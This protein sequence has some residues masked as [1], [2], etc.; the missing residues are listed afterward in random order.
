MNFSDFA[1]R[2]RATAAAFAAAAA[3]VAPAVA[4]VAAPAHPL[5]KTTL[6]RYEGDP[7]ALLSANP[8]GGLPLIARVRAFAMSD[9]SA[10]A[11][12]IALARNANDAQRAAIGAGLAS[13]VKALALSDPKAA[14][15]IKQ[16]VAQSGID[17]LITAFVA[18]SAPTPA[19]VTGDAG[20]DGD[21]TSGGPPANYPPG[22]APP[23]TGLPPASI[24]TNANPQTGAGGM[25]TST[26]FSVSPSR[27]SL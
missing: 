4:Q 8:A 5:S 13:A 1:A 9:P 19:V 6:E 25:T 27:T 24:F 15:A 12:L 20:V 14:D 2:S 23:G 16:Q 10:A 11:T 21:S 22:Q 7:Q 17:V 26:Q 3:V 18:A